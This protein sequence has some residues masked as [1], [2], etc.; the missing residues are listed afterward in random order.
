MK[1]KDNFFYYKTLNNVENIPFIIG[2][3]TQSM[4]EMIAKHSHDSIIAMYSTVSTN[5]YGVSRK[6]L[7]LFVGLDSIFILIYLKKYN[8][9]LIYLCAV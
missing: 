8:I 5:K 2:I 3:Q 7:I 4:Q 6:I 1:E 9:S